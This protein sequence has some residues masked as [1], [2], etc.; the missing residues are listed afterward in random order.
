[1]HCLTEATTNGVNLSYFFQKSIN[2]DKA[3][4]SCFMAGMLY[5]MLKVEEIDWGV[6]YQALVEQALEVSNLLDLEGDSAYT[7]LWNI[8]LKF[9]PLM[10][11]VLLIVDGL[12]E[13]KGKDKAKLCTSLFRLASLPEIRIVVSFQ[14]QPYLDELFQACPQVELTPQATFE[15]IER[16]I[17]SE[18]VQCPKKLSRIGPELFEVLRSNGDAV[19]LHVRMILTTLKAKITYDEQINAL[20]EPPAELFSSYESAMKAHN[21]SLPE[22]YRER[23]KD[24]FTIV[25]GSRQALTCDEVASA[26]ALHVDVSRSCMESEKRMLDP[27]ESI[28]ALCGPLIRV[29]QG[30]VS[31][32]HGSVKDFLIAPPNG[33]PAQLTIVDSDA[34]LAEKT[35]AALSQQRFQSLDR[36]AFLLR[37]NVDVQTNKD[38]VDPF[39]QYAATHWYV[40]L[41]AVMTPK[42]MLLEQAEKFLHGKEF[43]SWSEFVF[44]LKGSQGGVLEVRSTL[45]LWKQSLH[46]GAGDVLTLADY[47]E[48]PYR[49]AANMFQEMNSDKTLQ[50][51]CQYQLGEY[52]NLAG[53]IVE[54]FSVKK[55]VSEGLVKLLGQRHPLAL[56]AQS[57]FALE[58]LGQ[59]RFEEAEAE[60]RRLSQVQREVIGTDRPDCFQSQQRQAMAELWMTKFE[61]ANMNLEESLSGFLNTVGVRDFLYL[62]SELTM[63]QVFEYE[64]QVARASRNYERIWE[65][66]RSVFGPDNPMAVWARCALVSAYRKLGR[67]AEAHRAIDDVI[68][69]RTRILGTASSMTVDALIQEVVLFLDE[70]KLEEGMEAIDYILDGD[71]VEG[72]FERTVQVKHVLA[73]LD[74]SLGKPES[75]SQILSSLVKT[76]VD[77]G[78]QGRVR[79]LLW[80]RLDLA[81]ILRRQGMEDEALELFDELVRPIDSDDGNTW[82]YLCSPADW[83]T[84]E[85]ALRLVRDRKSN[86]ADRLLVAHGL[87]W[88]RQKDFWIL[89]GS[90][91]A[92]TSCMKRP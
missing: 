31:L 37:G 81:T 80:V 47:F 32:I 50:Y 72:S 22:E 68:D 69:T 38:D 25:V 82:N 19:F 60:F 54:A 91:P 29:L 24:I 18:I 62:M 41:T 88:M 59:R 51:L 27:Q 23:Q 73:V 86:E 65:Y 83:K 42:A 7:P 21:E 13:C 48:K 79:S 70:G 35:L 5:Q 46:D 4:A 74:V 36:I 63:G 90:P 92:D 9:L 16:Y 14:P 71:L 26:L 15:D 53:R 34:Y 1:M 55:A 57:A 30:T 75:A 20:K 61:A 78:S 67:F 33:R 39:Y 11:N 43:V 84:A 10:S 56:K 12:N 58:Y 8:V 49:D 76:S 89:N 17:A 64:G 28:I 45:N 40:H 87:Q 44:Q 85:H 52:F 2:S 77:K 6:N 3:T 66:R